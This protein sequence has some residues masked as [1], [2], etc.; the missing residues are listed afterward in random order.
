M[1]L[2]WVHRHWFRLFTGIVD[3]VD[4][5]QRKIWFLG[6]AVQRLRGW[7]TL[8]DKT[9]HW[10]QK[11]IYCQTHDEGTAQLEIR[12]KWD[13]KVEKDSLRLRE[14]KTR[15]YADECV[16]GIE[17]KPIDQGQDIGWMDRTGVPGQRSSLRFQRSGVLRSVEPAQLGQQRGGQESVRGS[18]KL[19]DFLHV[20][21]GR[22]VPNSFLDGAAERYGDNELLLDPQLKVNCYGPFSRSVLVIM[23]LI[24]RLL[25]SRG[26]GQ[27]HHPVQ[28][29]SQG[30]CRAGQG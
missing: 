14:P 11:Q 5:F 4:G 20:C 9:D 3:I 10:P 22:S 15:K 19:T 30:F 17:A 29:H 2:L 7:W 18:L 13:G 1:L 27:V 6:S 21:L 23:A 8:L 12:Y 16:E 28:L 24:Q 25:A 26:A